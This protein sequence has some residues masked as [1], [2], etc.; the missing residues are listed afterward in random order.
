MRGR[1]TQGDLTRDHQEVD[2]AR[3]REEHGESRDGG[4]LD[5]RGDRDQHRRAGDAL[6]DAHRE[7]DGAEAAVVGVA[8]DD[9]RVA[10]NDWILSPR[11]FAA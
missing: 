10:A 11:Q 3:H 4:W 2:P 7:P 1:V 6:V 9:R 5:G 8:G